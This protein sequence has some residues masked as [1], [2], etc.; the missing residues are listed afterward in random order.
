MINETTFHKLLKYYEL[1]KIEV[2]LIVPGDYG[3]EKVGYIGS[4]SGKL[5]SSWVRL[6]EEMAA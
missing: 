6:L 3:L 1:T 5:K 2:E 4:F